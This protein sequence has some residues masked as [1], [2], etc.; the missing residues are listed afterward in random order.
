MLVMHELTHGSI[1]LR[2]LL[3]ILIGGVLGYER[4][5][6]NRPAGLRTYM[7]VCLGAC[8]C[9]MINQYITQVYQTGDPVRLGAQVISG[10]GFLGAGSI[11]TV[12][13][14]RVSGLT[15]AAGLWASACIGLAIGVGLYEMAIMAGLA[16]FCILS[17]F[18]S[19]DSALHRRRKVIDI[20]VESSAESFLSS[21]IHYTREHGLRLSNLQMDN[22]RSITGAFT[23]IATISS[24]ESQPK[25]DILEVLKNAPDMQYIQE[26]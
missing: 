15:T 5:R 24:Q 14:N 6:L 25:E 17:V 11:L 8:I 1:F 23:F 19:I 2:I 12:G 3:S 16:A 7:L 21:F 18:Q 13:H 22:Q 9:M 20:Y 10:I 26:I 4:Q